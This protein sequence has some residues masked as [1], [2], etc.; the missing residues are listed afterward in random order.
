MTLRPIIR[1]P[2]YLIHLRSQPCLITGQRATEHE[3]VV[4]AHLGTAGKGLKSSDD[5]AIPLLNRLH[6]QSHA[7]G[8][9]SMLRREAP[10]WLIREAF[11]A[12]ARQYYAEWKADQS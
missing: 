9:V 10:D 11:R 8:E 1:D 3:S 5:C 6:H 4:A 12:L 7:S 2:A